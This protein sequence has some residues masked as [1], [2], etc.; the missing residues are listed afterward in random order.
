MD[1]LL[2]RILSLI[3]RKENGDF[4]HGA[5]KAFAES[6]GL[7]SGNLISDWIAGRSTSYESY[8]HEISHKYNVSVEWLYGEE[9]KKEPTI[10]SDDKLNELVRLFSSASPE[11]QQIALEILRAAESARNTRDED[12]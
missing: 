3:P 7:K 5:K 6:L 9:T 1:I 11:R 2:E 4:K 12:Y 8:V 10:L